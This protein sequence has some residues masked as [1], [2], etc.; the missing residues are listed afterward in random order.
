MDADDYLPEEPQGGHPGAGLPDVERREGLN[1]ASRG[2]LA[3]ADTVKRNHKV[4]SIGGKC[5]D[6]CLSL[7]S[8]NP[9]AWGT[10]EIVEYA[11]VQ[12]VDEGL[13]M[14]SFEWMEVETLSTEI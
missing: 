8:D 14:G 6:I 5:R 10:R 13:A 9:I 11:L 2:T 3:A 7:P 12:Y 1:P 4:N